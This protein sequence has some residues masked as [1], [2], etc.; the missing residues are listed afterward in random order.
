MASDL[1]V[2]KVKLTAANTDPAGGWTGNSQLLIGSGNRQ[3]AIAR[4]TDGD[5]AY[6]TSYEDSVGYKNLVLQG[7]GGN[8]G[9]GVTDPTLGTNNPTARSSVGRLNT[10]TGTTASIADSGTL[11]I[12]LTM[13]QGLMAYLIESNYNSGHMSAGF[14]R[15]NNNGAISNFTFF[16]QS[17]YYCNVTYPSAGNIRITNNT[18]GATTFFYAITVI[19][20]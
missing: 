14:F 1:T 13:P 19:A 20:G 17:E 11:D 18:G 16:G 2:G 10:Y 12:A 8:V 4:D 3:V 7:V 9:I 5:N 15:S 6:I